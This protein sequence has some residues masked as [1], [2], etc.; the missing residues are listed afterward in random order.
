M[1]KNFPLTLIVILCILFQVNQNSVLANRLPAGPANKIDADL[2]RKIDALQPGQMLSVIVTLQ[3]QADLTALSNMAGRAARQRAA[4]AALRATAEAAQRPINAFLQSRR[5]QGLVGQQTA[6]WVFNGLAVTA[7]PQVILELAARPDVATITPDAITIVATSPLMVNP[8]EQNLSIITAPDLWNL[9][10]YGQGVVVANMDSGVDVSHPDLSARWRGG[11]NSWF[12]PYGQHSTP[13]DLSGHGTQTM[14]VMIGGDAGGTSIGVAPQAQWIAVKIF[15]D[16]GSSTATAIHRGFQW[17][18][19]P[20]GN[21]NTADAPDVVNNSWAYGNPGCNLDFQLD[22]Q[23]LRAVGILPVFAAG[24][25]G[26]GSS[27]SVSPANYPEAFAVGAVDNTD[28]IYAS[29][30]RG[31][32]ACGE[33]QTIYPEIVAPGVNVKTTDLLGQ[34]DN[35]TGTSLSAPQAAGVLALLLNAYPN[36]TAYQQHMALTSGAADRGAAGP[37]NTFGYGRLNALASYQWLQAGGSTVTPTPTPL[38][39]ATPTP[40]PTATP[41]PAPATTLHV[42]DLDRSST[43]S[44]SKWNAIVTVYVHDNNEKPVANATVNGKWSNGATGTVSCNTNSSGSCQ[45]TKTGLNTKTT[46]V[47]FTVTSVTHSTLTYKSS[48][49]HDPDGDSNGTSIV[50]SKP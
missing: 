37:D 27:T 6:F 42:G 17:L 34:Y 30:S 44:G 41:T 50:I 7:A 24:N 43:L 47:T 22:L 14:G 25:Y 4:I 15:N 18:L 3:G 31:P 19:D 45:V 5:L 48:A 9:G 23:A 32:S 20:D 12:D 10:F 36:L 1:K 8:P 38:P 16:A 35:P 11:S 26:P 29:S 49:N 33:T 2:Q 39:T 40:M 46:S 28:Q 21:P 13:T